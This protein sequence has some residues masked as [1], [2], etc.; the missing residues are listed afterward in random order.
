VWIRDEVVVPGQ[1]VTGYASISSYFEVASNPYGSLIEV[2][3]TGSNTYFNLWNVGSRTANSILG[4]YRFVLASVALGPVTMR[5]CEYVVSTPTA[6]IIAPTAIASVTL[7]MSSDG[8]IGSTTSTSQQLVDFSSASDTSA[9]TMGLGAI[10]IGFWLF[11]A[12]R[13]LVVWYRSE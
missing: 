7:D 11:M 4:E 3:S 6:T 10:V 13:E 8:L 12:V 5:T 9:Y 2:G 1:T